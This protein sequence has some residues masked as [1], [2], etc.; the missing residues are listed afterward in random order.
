SRAL[1]LLRERDGRLAEV[2]LYPS[3]LPAAERR[4]MSGLLA[5]ASGFV[6]LGGWVW[7]QRRDA[8]ARTFLLLCLA[9]AWLLAPFPR[10]GGSL[11]PLAYETLYSGVSVFLPALFVHFFALFPERLRLRGRIRPVARIAYGVATTLFGAAVALTLWQ[12]ATGQRPE[13]AL[14]L[15]NGVAA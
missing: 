2:T 7:S 10:F 9:F 6:L 5:V 11:A 8:L 4:M 14:E 13:P 1:R 12:L 15:L 3:D